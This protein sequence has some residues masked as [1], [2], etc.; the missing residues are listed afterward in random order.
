MD[1][2]NLN[3]DDFKGLQLKRDP[4]ERIEFIKIDNK[5]CQV[6]MY[7]NGMAYSRY[8]WSIEDIPFRVRYYEALGFKKE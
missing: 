7:A 1:S 8:Q 3:M 5:D 2:Q 4:N 6:V